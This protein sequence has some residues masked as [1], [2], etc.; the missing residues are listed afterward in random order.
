MSSVTPSNRIRSGNSPTGTR[1]RA[2]L[3]PF[4]L[5][6]LAQ[7]A[8]ALPG[9]PGTTTQAGK[10]PLPAS[11]PAERAVLGACCY[12]VAGV[13]TCAFTTNTECAQ[14]YHGIFA[15]QGSNCD[16]SPCLLG[17]SGACCYTPPGGIP[18][19]AIFYTQECANWGGTFYGVGSSCTPGLC[20][21]Q[22]WGA[23]CFNGPN[24]PTCV[25]LIP[26][27]CDFVN[28]QFMGVGVPCNPNPC[29]RVGACCYLSTSGPTCVVVTLAE[30]QSLQGQYQGDGSTCSPNPCP[31]QGACCFEGPAGPTCAVMFPIECEQVNGQYQGNG[32]DCDPNP[33]PVVGRCCYLVQGTPNWQCVV[34]TAAE[35]D[36]VYNGSWGGANTNCNPPVVC[37]PQDPTGA[38]CYSDP[39]T[40][41]VTCIIVT[42][43][44]CEVVYHG[45]YHGDNST[46]QPNPCTET[47]ACCYQS[48][49]VVLCVQ[50]TPADC[51]AIYHGQFLGIGVPCAPGGGC[52]N[53]PGACCYGFPATCIVVSQQQCS[54][55]YGGTFLGPGTN[56]NP[57][58]C[59]QTGEGACCVT[60]NN[61]NS[62]CLIATQTQCTEVLH[63]IF[64][65]VG[66]SCTQE[67]CPNQTPT[68][69]CPANCDA[70]TPRFEDP[71]FATFTGPVAVCTRQDLFVS[72]RSLVI[73][74]LAGKNSAPFNTNWFGG[75]LYTHPSWV[76]TN[77]GTLFGVTLDRNGNIYATASTSYNW[78]S[79]GTGGW[80][81]IYKFNAVTALPSVWANL[82]NT[83]PGLG[84]IA[85]DAAASQFFVT[86][87]EDGR[88]Y[89]LDSTGAILSTFDHATNTIAGAG[90][91]PNDVPGFAPLGERPW[92]IAV[93]NNRVYYSL[94][95]EDG[96]RPNPS[97][98]NQI[99]SIALSG[100]NF[101]GAPQLEINLPPQATWANYSAPVSD[102]S[103]S[104]TGCML[105][106]ERSM[107]ADT[108]ASAHASRVFKYA[109]IG[110][111]W[112]LTPTYY[113][114]GVIAG[115]ANSAGGADFDE[116]SDVWATGDALQFSPQTIYGLQG[117]DCNGGTVNTSIL[118][119][120]NGNLTWQDKTLLG[121]VEVTCVEKCAT[122]PRKMTAWF[123]L[124]ETSGTTALE[125]AWGNN[126]AYNGTTSIAGKVAN[127]RRFNG[128]SDY[129][130]VPNASQINFGNSD[131]SVDAWVRTIDTNGV[132]VILDKRSAA[133]IGYSFFL[134][135]GRPGLQLA[136]AGGYANFIPLGSI[137]N[138]QWR[139]LAVTV[140]RASATGITFY[141]DG[142]AV[143]TYNPLPYPGTVTNSN[144]LWIGVREPLQGGGGNFLGDLDEI[145]LFNRELS[146]QDVQKL[147]RAGAKGKCKERAWL[148]PVTSYCWFQNVKTVP[149]TIFNDS[150]NNYNYTWSLLGNNACSVPGPGPLGFSPQNG[151]AAINALSSQTWNVNITK[152]AGLGTACYD[153]T[154]VNTT[155]SNVFG[156]S[157]S[158][159]AAPW[160]WC[161]FHGGGIPIDHIYKDLAVG[162][163]RVV[164]FGVTNTDSTPRS[165]DCVIVAQS[166]DGDSS[167]QVISLNGLPPGEPVLRSLS[168]EPNESVQIPVVVK[169]L[170]HQPFNVH[171]LVLLADDQGRGAFTPVASAGLESS[172]ARCLGDAD[173]SG[174]VDFFD[175]D[176]FVAKLG[177]PGAGPQCGEGCP[178]QNSDVDQDGDVDFFDI[179]PFVA[180]L[181]EVCP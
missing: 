42:A 178:W 154:V 78:P 106:S 66:S 15:G 18:T 23:C 99:W 169:F 159:T 68:C 67:T 53:A 120:L 96:G 142:A 104:S 136:D 10:Q 97:V 114:V 28:G 166:S 123:P 6:A 156:T 146:A 30:C 107:F 8:F 140:N 130:K 41:A 143:A 45:V 47:G 128:Q 40:G 158:L 89:R 56:C 134:Y 64:I 153:A 174:I 115:G 162:T 180:H 126:G 58:P 112:W 147:Y 176:P 62:L 52:P 80:G 44:E 94:W 22:E 90:P 100:G 171:D 60:D 16:P 73:V 117:L 43:Y 131:F 49:G 167:N 103:F 35:C 165:L 155:T 34:T 17:N 92:G 127:A 93:W 81:T 72:N 98:A 161:F 75:T 20:D 121:D 36:A 39:A 109:Q 71:A 79:I 177:C 101:S 74:N 32:T 173:C 124:D 150:G 138:G 13:P 9:A 88:I 148:P 57:N 164:A 7:V 122:P 69:K 77:V 85:Y 102:I 11:P 160:K 70:R 133:T 31:Q 59:L 50:T 172:P 26:L 118:V 145:E 24:G 139:H 129:V 4:A 54:E 157:A 151:G 61:G 25:F 149:F 3:L 48:Q 179:D 2:R 181:G 132:K 113:G 168:L 111:V 14:V 12:H 141:V 46:C 86:N 137:A 91:D 110:P 65:G 19:C 38:C 5:V 95:V 83:G 21:P 33:C 84:N 108:G 27:E 76:E 1:C 37:G 119:D 135:Q 152:P 175:I 87:F 163:A 144:P 55:I 82:P 116:D 105:V 51:D 170:E 29:P 63:G 125:I